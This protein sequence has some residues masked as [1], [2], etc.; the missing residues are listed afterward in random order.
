MT[1]SPDVSV[2]I[3]NWNTRELLRECLA[4]LLPPGGPRLEVV[5]V[6]NGSTDG[7]AEAVGAEFPQVHLVATG[8]NLG[9]AKAN[10]VGFAHC[11]GRYVVLLNSDALA[12]PETLG[13]M[14]KY[15]EQQAEVGALGCQL[16][17]GD[18]SV[19][20][21]P[22][23]YP[24]VGGIAGQLLLGRAPRER[25]RG[26]GVC[27]VDWLS[28]ACLMVRREVIDAVGGLNE[29]YFMYVED[30]EW[31]Y[32]LRQHGWR[33]VYHP[34]FQVVH[35]L[36]Q[37]GRAGAKSYT[38]RNYR[39]T[40]AF[41]AAKESGVGGRVKLLGLRGAY[42]IGG[43]LHALGYGLLHLARPRDPYYRDRCEAYAAVV[44]LGLSQEPPGPTR[45]W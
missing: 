19:Q 38:V 5:V 21:W 34:G 37:S 4:A 14:A 32:R 23:S 36:G 9:F 39:N 45:R 41:L 30:T 10:N 1:S 22:R 29:A 44:G 8:E 13:A 3:V 20:S 17:N 43:A 42:V 11:H 40:R 35:L 12:A 33:V 27:E 15:L 6:D 2:V 31:C 25:P 26:P 16:L 7:S 18:G 24:T 28:G